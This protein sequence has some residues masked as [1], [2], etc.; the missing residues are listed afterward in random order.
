MG[1]GFCRRE[2]PGG[3]SAGGSRREGGSAGGSRREEG[4]AG[5]SRREEG[6]ARADRRGSPGESQREGGFCRWEPTGDWRGVLQVGANGGPQVRSLREI[7]N[8]HC[9]PCGSPAADVAQVCSADA[10]TGPCRMELPVPYVTGLCKDNGPI[11]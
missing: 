6:S 3:G 1:R 8:L 5:E 2:L 10:P 9:T 4:S 7:R 11:T